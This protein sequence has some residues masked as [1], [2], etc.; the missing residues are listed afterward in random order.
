MLYIW[1]DNDYML[2]RTYLNNQY[3]TNFFTRTQHM[4]CKGPKPECY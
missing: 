1:S 2:V 3:M 4:D